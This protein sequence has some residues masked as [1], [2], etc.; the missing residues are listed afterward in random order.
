M[1]KNITQKIRELLTPEDLKIFEGAVESMIEDKV[2]SK[3]SDLIQLKE[4]ELKVKYDA[5]A[6]AYVKKTVSEMMIVKKA[7]LVESYDKKLALLEQK[8][9]T[10]LDSYLNHVISEQISDA[11]LEKIAI[12]ETLMP[13][14]EGI[15]AVFTDNHLKI[16]SKAQSAI[17][18]L[19]TEMNGIKSELSESIDK[20]IMLETE[21]ERSAVYLLIAEKTNGF[22]R[23]DKQKVIDMFKDKE[24]DEVDKNID[25]YLGL[26]KESTSIK[27]NKITSKTTV[28]QKPKSVNEGVVIDA[29]KEP[30]KQ[31]L[32]ESEMP[33]L[34]DIANRFLN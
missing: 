18:S 24:F 33:T 13:V 28:K 30:V 16:N 10:K 6:E 12:N 31:D 2:Q 5:L 22:K 9:V 19:K 25:N 11:M 14:V 15:R 4:A 21:L 23:T 17:E 8:V 26:I 1:S 34:S 32:N 20:R 7:K 29:K 3:L 27:S